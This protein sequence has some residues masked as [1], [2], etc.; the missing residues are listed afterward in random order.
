MTFALLGWQRYVIARTGS[1]AISADHVH[2]QSDLLF[3]FGVIAALAL[4]RYA[5]IGWAD[6]LIGFS[7][8]IW[9]GWGAYRA[10]GEAIDH[11]MDREWP[12][13]KRRA[14]VERVARHPEL[15]RLHDLR[16][17]TAGTRDFVQFHFEVPEDMTV[18]DAHDIM[19]RVE[20]DLSEAF[21]G[22]E[23]L[24]HVDPAGQID[25]PGNDL[26]EASEFRQAGRECREGTV[27]DTFASLLACRCLRRAALHRK[28][29]R[30]DAAR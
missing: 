13:D 2:Y 10:A 4:D 7:I 24:M 23:I 26:V 1:V 22:T 3:N 30:R 11:L 5:R 16:T 25:D 8:A 6:P 29:G 12:E 17:R 20:T 27:N 28:P 18:R 15:A 9:L 19:E 14:F 21:P